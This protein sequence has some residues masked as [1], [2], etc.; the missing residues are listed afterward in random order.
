MTSGHRVRKSRSQLTHPE[1]TRRPQILTAASTIKESSGPQSS[2]THHP[3][4]LSG[5]PERP[6]PSPTLGLR[7]GEEGTWNTA[8]VSTPRRR[9]RGPRA[10]R[11][12]SRAPNLHPAGGVLA[13]PNMGRAEAAGR[14]HGAG[15][16]RTAGPKLDGADGACVSP[17]KPNSK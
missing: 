9:G 16:G 7:E 3:P 11:G 13:A 8:N 4:P 15:W 17:W 10:V 2:F 5:V 1:Q 6:R 12:W 14:R